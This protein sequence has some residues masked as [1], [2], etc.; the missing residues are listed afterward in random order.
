M[1]RTT[2]TALGTA[3]LYCA[4]MAFPGWSE[5][6]RHPGTALAADPTQLAET[7]QNS[8]LAAVGS[9]DGVKTVQDLPPPPPPS[10][11]PLPPSRPS[12]ELRSVS[13]FSHGESRIAERKVPASPMRGHSSG[14]SHLRASSIDQ[15]KVTLGRRTRNNSR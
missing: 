1:T 2:T 3:A 5:G 8:P 10:Y 7:L 11:A 6:G 14:P 4:L 9:A 15:H 12:A 13:G